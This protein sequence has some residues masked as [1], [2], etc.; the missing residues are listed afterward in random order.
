MSVDHFALLAGLLAVAILLLRTRTPEA[1]RHQ[2]PAVGAIVVDVDTVPPGE[3]TAR[4]PHGTR[5]PVHLVGSARRA[6]AHQARLDTHRVF[7]HPAG[8]RQAAT[9][10]G[11]LAGTITGPVTVRTGDQAIAEAIAATPDR[12]AD[13]QP[14]SPKRHR[15][16]SAVP[17]LPGPATVIPFPASRRAVAARSQP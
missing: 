11:Y 15:T 14:A 9:V 6:A 1:C 3:V 16:L 10:I 13:M 8:R 4:D 12:P 17:D 5:R 2:A 7:I